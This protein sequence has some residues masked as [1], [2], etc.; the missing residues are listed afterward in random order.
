MDI[1]VRYADWK[2][3]F[4]PTFLVA[5]DQDARWLYFLG[6]VVNETDGRTPVVGASVKILDGYRSDAICTTNA[7]GFCSIHRI[8]TGETFTTQVTKSGYRPTTFSY[9]VD[10]PVGPAGSN[11][12]FF[13]ITL[14]RDEP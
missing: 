13:G 9:R 12:P 11:S 8:L 7:S 3:D 5:P 2:A 4:M 10:P 1:E 6:L 14:T